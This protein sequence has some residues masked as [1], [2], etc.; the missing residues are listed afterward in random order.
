MREPSKVNF[1]ADISSQQCL[2]RGILPFALEC[3][4]FTYPYAFK[5]YERVHGLIACLL[6][7]FYL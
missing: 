1:C 7:I 6:L 5:D 2:A 3:I 4:A